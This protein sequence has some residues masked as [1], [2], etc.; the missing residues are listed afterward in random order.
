MSVKQGFK[1]KQMHP[2]LN[3]RLSWK[4]FYDWKVEISGWKM[5]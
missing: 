5:M 3:V 1:A 2:K 4:V